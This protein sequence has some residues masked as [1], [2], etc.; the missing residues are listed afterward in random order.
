[1]GKECYAKSKHTEEKMASP[2]LHNTFRKYHRWL[3]FFLSGIMLIYATSGILLIFRPTEFLKFPQ[4]EVRHL[5]L[6][7]SAAALSENLKMRGFSVKSE[8]PELIVFNKGQYNKEK[9]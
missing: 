4:T 7:M 2:K 5:E 3:G 6:N 9:A 8:T 1:M